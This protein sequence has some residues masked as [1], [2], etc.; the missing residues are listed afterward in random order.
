M[1]FMIID[2]KDDDKSFMLD[3]NKKYYGLIRKSLIN[4]IYD[5]NDIEDLINDTFVSLIERTSLIRVLNDRQLATYIYYTAKSVAINFI[6]HRDVQKKNIYYSEDAD[7]AENIPVFEEEM[8]DRIIQQKEIEYLRKAL[9]KLPEKQRDIL[10]SKYLLKMSDT[11]I[12]NTF[13]IAP[14]SVRQYLTRAR[15][16]AKNLIEKEMAHVEKLKQK[17]T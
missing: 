6:R 4:I 9:K 14:A 11:E 8:T 7:L 10:R 5:T 12:A 1:I 16:S 3:L 13:G 2:D 15:R 17:K